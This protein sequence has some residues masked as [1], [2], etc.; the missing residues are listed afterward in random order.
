MASRLTPVQTRAV[1]PE[2]P[3]TDVTADERLARARAV[4]ELE[5]SAIA[6]L[7][8]RLD[9]RF[10]RAV[11]LL[12]SCT[13]RV[14]VTGVGKS[15]HVGKK[16][17]ATLCCAG[18]PSLFVHGGEAAH[19]DLG[20]IARGDVLL[21]ISKSGE[22]QELKR[23][24]P[25]IREREI[26]IVALVGR[27]G[28]TIGRW[29]DVVLEAPVEREACPHD[30]IPT[31]SAIAAMAMG[32]ALAMA[33]VEARGFSAE[34]FA[35]LHPGGS[36]GQG[37][38]TRVRDSMLT[39]DLPFVST[40]TPVGE[41]LVIMTRGCCGL[42]IVVDEQ[43]TLLGVV[44]DGDLRRALQRRQDLRQLPISEIMTRDPVTIS[45]DGT[46]HEAQARMLRLK[47]QSLIVLD[48]ERRVTG[49]IQ[50]FNGS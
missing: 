43:R 15:G 38:N 24:I 25:S 42:A 29:A 48:A 41:A 31:T 12:Q 50:I 8:K 6:S 33:L 7:A 26:P 1:R 23:I 9:D 10:C 18:T 34:D 45:E 13:G 30:L 20:A 37:F 27:A 32:D 46:L 16:L 14:I 28:S 39:T 19:G 11:D 44:T 21:V 47:L 2:A 4:L 22:V 40:D 36:L 49:V 5:S 17:A 3:A 35:S